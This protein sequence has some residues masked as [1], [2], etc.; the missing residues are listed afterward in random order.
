VVEPTLIVPRR[1]FLIRALGFTAGGA[2]MAVPI[3]TV[4]SPEKRL[5]H[6]L[7]AAGAAMRELFPGYGVKVQGNCLDG[8]HPA[9]LDMW[10]NGDSFSAC[11]MVSAGPHWT[12]EPR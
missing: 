6:H 4:D 7:E 9:Y 11:A 1:N 10:K 12:G 2:A 3:V 5:R 8:H